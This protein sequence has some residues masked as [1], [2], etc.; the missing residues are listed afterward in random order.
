MFNVLAMAFATQGLMTIASRMVMTLARDQ[1]VG[2]LSPWLGYVSPKLEVPT[3][4]IVFT[5]VW[6]VIF[7]LICQCIWD[8]HS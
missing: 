4:S 1:G 6:V 8:E 5:S 7:G 2:H 3:W